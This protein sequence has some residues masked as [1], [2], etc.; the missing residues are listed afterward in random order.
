MLT[1]LNFR[2]KGQAI[3]E[4]EY[5]VV[6]NKYVQTQCLAILLKIKCTHIFYS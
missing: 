5:L 3:I 4:I 1:S 6:S 2:K